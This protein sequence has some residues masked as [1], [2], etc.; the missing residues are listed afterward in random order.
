MKMKNKV[1]RR[2]NNNKLP[3]TATTIETM[4]TST[5]LKE[6]RDTLNSS[7]NSIKTFSI[8]LERKIEKQTEKVQIQNKDETV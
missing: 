7:L 2:N 3:K 4:W 6:L 1:M 8:S 5:C